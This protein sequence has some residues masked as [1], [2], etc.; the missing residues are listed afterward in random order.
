MIK[1]WRNRKKVTSEQEERVWDR[2]DS[3]YSKLEEGK[4]TE[5]ELKRIDGISKIIMDVLLQRLHFRFLIQLQIN[6][7]GPLPALLQQFGRVGPKGLRFRIICN[8]RKNSFK[9]RNGPVI[10]IQPI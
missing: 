3:L 9:I 4:A 10:L 1:F 8:Q 2:I 7:A 5:D 6:W